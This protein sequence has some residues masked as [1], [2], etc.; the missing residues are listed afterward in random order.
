M[1]G[2]TPG[3]QALDAGTG[4]LEDRRIVDH[5]GRL[6]DEDDAQGGEGVETAQGKPIDDELR[7]G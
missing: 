4:E 3:S 6:E 7:P 2:S 5:G 1:L